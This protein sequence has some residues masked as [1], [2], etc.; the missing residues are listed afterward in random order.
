MAFPLNPTDGQ[1]YNNYTYDDSTK[2][3]RANKIYQEQL[4]LGAGEG[5]INAKDIVLETAEE[6]VETV[7]EAIVNSSIKFALVLG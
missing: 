6:S 7:Q 5:Q 4:D 3:W 1:R 2:T